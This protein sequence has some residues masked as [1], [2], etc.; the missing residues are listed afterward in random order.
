MTQVFG[1]IHPKTGNPR[2]R[3]AGFVCTLFNFLLQICEQVALEE[4]NDTDLQAVTDL[5]QGGNG[6]T[7]VA[8]ADDVAQGRLGDTADG[9]KLI[10]CD[11]VLSA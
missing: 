9:R 11:V 8:S 2:K 7:V 3:V 5:F 4:V 6:G 10:D 1:R